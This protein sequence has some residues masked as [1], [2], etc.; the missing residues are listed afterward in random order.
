MVDGEL[1]G[2]SDGGTVVGGLVDSGTC[3]LTVVVAGGGRVVVI[4]EVVV[5]G[6]VEDSDTSTVVGSVDT[7]SGGKVTCS[8][9]SAGWEDCSPPPSSF[10]VSPPVMLVI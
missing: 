10:E 3:S 8:R 4:V 2:F 7:F 6:A 5:T 1:G 9:S